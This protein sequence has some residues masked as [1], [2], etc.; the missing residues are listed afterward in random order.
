MK[1]CS[2][3]V[4]TPSPSRFILQRYDGTG[5]FMDADVL[6]CAAAD[7]SLMVYNTLS[8]NKARSLLNAIG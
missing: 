8:A 7:V 1:T 3:C 2:L 6:V 4:F 5:D